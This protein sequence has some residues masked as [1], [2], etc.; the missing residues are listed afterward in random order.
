MG[1][2]RDGEREHAVEEFA[3]EGAHLRELLGDLGEG[4][5]LL[6]EGTHG[7]CVEHDNRESPWTNDH[8]GDPHEGGELVARDDEGARLHLE[9]EPG[10]SEA[11]NTALA[12]WEVAHTT[13]LPG[14]EGGVLDD[15]RLDEEDERPWVT[16]RRE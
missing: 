9:N 5:R 14:I 7:G 2:D 11:S 4:R 12:G 6:C 13:N 10:E 16:A 8:V 3:V 1:K 15:A